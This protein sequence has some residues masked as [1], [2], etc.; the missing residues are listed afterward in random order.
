MFVQTSCLF[1]ETAVRKGY[2]VYFTF[3][4]LKY[5]NGSLTDVFHFPYN[6]PATASVPQHAAWTYRL[7]WPWIGNGMRAQ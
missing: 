7:D 1:H 6:F 4:W 3:R 2:C 5:I